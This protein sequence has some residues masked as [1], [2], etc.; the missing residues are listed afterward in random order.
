MTHTT[1]PPK[2]EK[3]LVWLG[4]YFFSN[5]LPQS[6]WRLVR[7]PWQAGNPVN[8]WESILALTGGEIPDVVVL[9]DSSGPPGLVGMEEFPCLTVF[10]SV[11]SHIHSW[12]P[13]Y[14]QGFDV[15]LV[16]LPQFLPEFAKGRLAPSRVWWS[17]PYATESARPPENMPPPEWDL[18]FVGTVDENLAP[19]RYHFLMELKKQLPGFHFTTGPF[20]S[21]YP[22][23]RLVLNEC[24]RGELNF[25]VFEALGCGGCLLTPDI[26]PALTD[27]FSDGKEL[28]LYPS[29]NAHEVARLAE[30]LLADE[31]LRA[32]VAKAGLATIDAGHRDSHRAR[33]FSLKL[34]ELFASGE[35][36][37]MIRQRKAASAV[38]HHD[39][40]RM[41]YLLHAEAV[42]VEFLRRIYLEAAKSGR[43]L[44]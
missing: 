33:S 41:L 24:T 26:G 36:A 42:P 8:T 39:I 14:A 35:A 16:S 1:S 11:D 25:R 2:A 4:H 34:H 19:E 28:F 22:K 44:P 13:L 5:T 21:L 31:P 6:G 10:Y 12:H 27:L 29:R 37:N 23:A 30:R 40:L 38:I 17:P 32:R 15:C 9:A 18:L 7:E 3:L 20:V 43:H